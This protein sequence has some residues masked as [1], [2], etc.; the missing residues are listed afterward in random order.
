MASS[1]SVE[2]SNPNSNS[3]P[4][5]P[6]RPGTA[7]DPSS[8]T[9]MGEFMRASESSVPGG[10]VTRWDLTKT[11]PQEF[12]HDN[13]PQILSLSTHVWNVGTTVGMI[14]GYQCE[15]KLSMSIMAQHSQ[16][17]S[18]AHANE[19]YDPGGGGGGGGTQYKWPYGDVPQTWVP[20][21][22]VWYINDPLFFPF[23]WYTRGW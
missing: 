19:G 11:K 23:W 6:G 2:G 16:A 12:T 21:S 1:G 17:D 14:P 22:P 18:I 9:M 4:E 3:P 15:S 13:L 8:P 7:P 10:I 20:I 5:A